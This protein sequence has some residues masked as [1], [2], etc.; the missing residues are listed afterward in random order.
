MNSNTQPQRH[1][2]RPHNPL[3]SNQAIPTNPRRRRKSLQTKT[4]SRQRQVNLRPR[5]NTLSTMLR[6]RNNTRTQNRPLL[7]PRHKRSLNRTKPLQM[8]HTIH[9]QRSQTN[10]TTIRNPRARHFSNKSRNNTDLNPH[11]ANTRRHHIRRPSRQHR[12]QMHQLLNSHIKSRIRSRPTIRS[13]TLQRLSHLTLRTSRSN[14]RFTH[15]PQ[16]RIN[17]HTRNLIQTHATLNRPR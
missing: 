7:H 10:I 9:H 14:N 8:I 4:H 3:R 6:K 12:T 17:R 11:I 2:Q 15:H 1:P 16:M 5:P 13:L